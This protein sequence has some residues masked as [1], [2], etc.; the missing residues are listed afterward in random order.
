MAGR[1]AA[2]TH[3]PMLL[4]PW[5]SAHARHGAD[6]FRADVVIAAVPGNPHR[7]QLGICPRSP[8]RKPPA[9]PTQRPAS[10]AA[11]TMV[12]VSPSS[13]RCARSIHRDAV[14]DASSC[15]VE[16][17]A[18]G[19]SLSAA[20][21]I[22]R[23]SR[24]SRRCTVWMRILA[25]WL[26]NGVAAN[27]FP[28]GPASAT[29][30]RCRTTKTGPG[31]GSGRR[32]PPARG[33]HCTRLP[34]TD[35]QTLLIAVARARAE[36]ITPAD[37]MRRWQQD[38]FVRPA[39]ADPRRVAAVEARLWQ[40]LP[41]E[42]T[43]IDLSPVTPLGTC[44]A[45]APLSQNRVVA[46]IRTTEVVSDSTNTLAV[47]A[48]VRRR[49]QPKDGHADLAACQ[50]Q[51]RAQVFGPGAAAHFRL[52]RPGLQRPR[53]RVRPH[54]GQPAHPA[55]GLLA[56]RARHRAPAPA[57]AHRALG[58]R[59]PGARR[60]AHRHRP[61][62]PGRA[63][64]SFLIDKPDRTRGRGYYTG[65]ALRITEEQ[66]GTELGDGGFTSWTAQL[67][68]DAKE[69]CLV[70]CIATERLTALAGQERQL[71]CLTGTI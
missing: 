39:A 37:V 19:A 70:S 68:Q 9:R 14:S 38:R 45:V 48:A 6:Q 56:R 53:Q 49:G 5:L 1:L 7:N 10:S 40:L 44:T 41:A 13:E 15:Q 69:R 71:R 62:G 30:A 16:A 52:V 57:A 36:Q 47:E 64:G 67:T 2:F 33:R 34:P 12:R 31:N 20:S 66:S 60:T 55:P 24:Q 28:A 8:G 22:S 26:L 25:G 21:L 46:T 59:Q 17:K 18:L 35:L 63:H 51:L 4:A 54:R 3:R 58:V 43:G 11:I 42:F 23:Y 61:P 27:S 50:R 32:C 29:V 65:L